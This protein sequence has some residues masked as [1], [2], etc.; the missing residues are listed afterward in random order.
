[1]AGIFDGM[2]EYL[3]KNTPSEGGK[4]M[5][6]KKKKKKKES[7]QDKKANTKAIKSDDEWED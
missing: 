7:K 4:G 3:T 6:K 5:G 2:F 1:M